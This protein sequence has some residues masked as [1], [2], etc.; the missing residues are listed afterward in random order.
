MAKFLITLNDRNQISDVTLYSEFEYLING[1]RYSHSYYA[2]WIG[3]LTSCDSTVHNIHTITMITLGH[4]IFR[5][6]QSVRPSLN[7]NG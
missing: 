4:F 3:N 1:E 2:W 5:S 6:H 7:R